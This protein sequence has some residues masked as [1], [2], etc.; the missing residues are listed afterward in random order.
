MA[1]CVYAVHITSHPGGPPG[2]ETLFLVLC[3]PSIGAMALDSAG[4]LGGIV[5]WVF[6]SLENAGLYGLVGLLCGH[7]IGKSAN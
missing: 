5:G 4:V 2:N 3:P 6:I 1:L 7:L